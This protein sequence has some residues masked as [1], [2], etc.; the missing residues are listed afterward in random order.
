[1]KEQQIHYQEV[2]R[3]VFELIFHP[4]NLPFNTGKLM[5]YVDGWIQQCDSVICELTA[6]YFE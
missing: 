3:K 6:D 5:I 4:L 2:L 1:M